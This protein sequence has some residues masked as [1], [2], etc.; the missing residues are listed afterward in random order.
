MLALLLALTVASADTLLVIA[1]RGA[2]GHRPEHTLAAYRLAVEMGADVIE[3]DVV[4]TKDGVLIARHENEISGTTDVASRPE[5]ASRR[6]TKSIDGREVSGWFTEDFTLAEIQTLRAIER[7]PDLRSTA[8]DGQYEVPTLDEVIALARE[9]G[10]A[11]GRPVGL[12]PETKHPGYFRSIGLPLEAPLLAAL[13]GAGF[14]SREDPVWIQSF[15][16]EN[17]RL[18]R[19]ATD[20]RLVQL[21][22]PGGAPPDRP[23]LPY[24]AMMTP[25]G[26]AEIAT[27]ADAVGVAKTFVLDETTAAP[28]NLVARA[29]A[30]GLAVHVW[31]VRA[32]N[33]FLLPLFRTTGGPEA[34]GDLAGEVRALV[35]AGV[36]GL[37]SDH[38]EAVLQTVR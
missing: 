31:T 1:H 28:T 10:E 12:Y 7:L 22:S 4:S 11:R 8:F 18:L 38:P 36:D 29:H 34:H 24:D 9:M 17:L 16:V 15:E 35:A 30:A 27:Y 37:F 23:G 6:T 19:G 13:H 33:A 14:T 21:A 32:E 5:F 26:L 20:L 25:E 2:S 3:P